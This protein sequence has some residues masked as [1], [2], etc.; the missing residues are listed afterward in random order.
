[1]TLRFDHLHRL[2]NHVEVPIPKDADGFLGRECPQSSCESY[3][4]IKPGTGLKGSNLPCKCPYCGHSGPQNTFWTQDQLEYAKSVALRQI[5]DAVRKDLKKLEFEHRPRGAFGIGISMKLQPGAPLPIRYYRE[6]SLETRV[7][8]DQ[9]TLDYAV[10]GVFAYCPDC[11][12]H[13]SLQILSRNLELTTKQLDLAQSLN[14]Q[15]LRQHLIEDA[16]EDCV[17]AFDGFAREACRIRSVKSTDPAK[18]ASLS[19]QNLQRVTPRLGAL[20]GIDLQASIASDD[21]EAAHRAFMRRHLLA[22][23][24]GVIDQQYLSETGEPM[25]LLGRRLIVDAREVRNLVTVV[26]NIG[27]RLLSLLPTP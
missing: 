1:M 20:F 26:Q 7:T 19:F 24:A 18:A 21:W 2:G 16:L 11:G 15:D 9:C 23:K 25:Q 13:N 22:H 8:C 17:S 27:R 3:F 14:D 10:F 6:K 4:K 5:T 12:V